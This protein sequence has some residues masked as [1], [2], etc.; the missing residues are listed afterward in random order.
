MDDFFAVLIGSIIA[1]VLGVASTLY[2]SAYYVSDATRAAGAYAVSQIVWALFLVLN[3]G[4]TYASREAVRELFERRWRAGIG[5]KRILIAGAGDLGRHGGRPRPAAPGARL[6]RGGLHRRP[7]RRRFDR[8][9]RAA[10]CSA[11]SPRWPRSRTASA[12]TTST[13]RC[14]SRTMPSSWR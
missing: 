14:R 8:L 7:R 4:F 12:S 1:V 10:R 13:W 9:P 6:S 5:L 2:V 3:V 11:R